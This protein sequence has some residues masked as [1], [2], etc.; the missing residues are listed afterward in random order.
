MSTISEEIQSSFETDQQMAIVNILY[1][2]NWLKNLH[3]EDLKKFNITLQQYNI[4]RILRGGKDWMAMNDVKSRM[5]EKS[6]NATRLADKLISSEFIERKRC[7]VDRRVVYVKI[8]SKGKKLLK[9]IDDQ[10]M[11]LP[12]DGF[13]EN[14][15]ADEAKTLSNLLDKLRG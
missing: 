9:T 11:L 2:A 12:T 1:T 15:S 14:L 7:D 8:T 5:I 3:G 10:K 13:H 4:L 6:P